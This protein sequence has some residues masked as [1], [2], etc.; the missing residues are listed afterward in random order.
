MT[1][2]KLAIAAQTNGDIPHGINPFGDRLH[3]KFHQFIGLTCELI[4]GTAHRIHR[5]GANRRRGLLLAIFIGKGHRGCW[6]KTATAAHL[7]QLELILGIG[8]LH[9]NA[10]NRFQIAICNLSFAIGKILEAGKGII[11]ILK[12][13]V[14]AE[15]F[16]A[17]PNSA[18]A[19]ELA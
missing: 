16:Q 17:S 9:L 10:D 18:A 4:E 5:S 6:L 3:R 8:L 2:V 11:E 1:G 19:T 15:L 13:E 12:A 7:H 14:I